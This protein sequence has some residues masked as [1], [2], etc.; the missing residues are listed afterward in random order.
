MTQKCSKRVFLKRASS[1]AI[2]PGLVTGMSAEAH[3]QSQDPDL[4]EL[5]KELAVQSLGQIVRPGQPEY[6]KIK[7]YNAR[8]DC[9]ATKAYI[10][11][12]STEGVRKILEW[13]QR[14]RRTFAIRGAGHSFEGK[15]SHPDLVIDMSRLGRLN[16]KGDGTL[17]VEAGV[18]LGDVYNTLSAAGYVLPAGTCP[19]VGIV[20]HTLGGGIGDFLPMFGYAAQSLT[21][22][23]L[24]TMAG[25]ILKVSDE[26]IEVL[27][28]SPMPASDLKARDLMKVLRGGGQ[29]SV[30]IVTNMIF[31]TYDV[32]AAKLASFRL[33]GANGVSPR[34]SIAIIQTWQAWRE[35]LPKTMQG[36]VSSKLNLSRSGNGYGLDIAGLIVIPSTSNVA[37]ADVRQTLNGLFQTPEF[38]KK[39][40]SKSLNA[41]G[42][43]KTFLDDDETSH[44][45]KR[46]M[47]YG[48]S[49]ALPAA[50]PAPAVD[51]LIRSLTD[52]IF[53]SFYTSGGNS[54]A[55]PETSLHPSEFLI[56]W[57]TYSSRRNP[58]APR[59]IRAINSEVMKLSGFQDHAF[60]NYPDDQFRD[61]FPNRPQV[62]LVKNLLDPAAL[63]TSSLLR[64]P[65]PAGDCR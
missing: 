54:K 13:A 53:A 17:E 31:K 18:V 5:A 25:S 14:H 37:M 9:A 55:G 49:S 57:S 28:G 20:G 12:A 59:R 38:E 39:D 64:E 61:Y 2:Y 1:L 29:G 45:R 58:D 62:E 33:D 51:Y 50:L 60:P 41:A 36:L 42:A 24:V 10:R 32:R 48:S 15:S 34:R 44:N 56:E 7:Y 8:F 4:D 22:A 11:P 3:A 43:I 65:R 6:S 27:G 47:L 46:K 26:A 63:S 16:F 52:S 35:S 19:T 21:A 30:G 23:T 40:F